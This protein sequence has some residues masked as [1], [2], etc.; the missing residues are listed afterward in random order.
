M[1]NLLLL[2]FLVLFTACKD[3]PRKNIEAKFE[4]SKET[5]KKKRP[6]AIENGKFFTANGKKCYSVE[7]MKISILT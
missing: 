2:V 6:L 3:N 4:D 5:D 1:R 7:K